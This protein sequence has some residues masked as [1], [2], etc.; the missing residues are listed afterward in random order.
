M[1]MMLSS[2]S[3]RMT[4]NEMCVIWP[5][6]NRRSGLSLTV[7]AKQTNHSPKISVSVQPGRNLNSYCL[8]EEICVLFKFH[9][10]GDRFFNFR[11]FT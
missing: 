7:S 6:N 8:K 2:I 1:M 4:V 11:N 10:K 3:R 9:D 5:S